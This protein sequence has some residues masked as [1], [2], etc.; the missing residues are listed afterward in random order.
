[1]PGNV[2]VAVAHAAL[3]AGRAADTAARDCCWCT[4]LPLNEQRLLY[5]GRQLEDRH[6]LADYGIRRGSTLELM[7][8]LR[9]GTRKRGVRRTGAAQ[10]AANAQAQAVRSGPLAATVL[11]YCY[12]LLQ[13]AAVGLTPTEPDIEQSL[14]LQ[15]PLLAR[16]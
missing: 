4:G 10:A 8:R 11:H 6:M 15:D 16:E 5:E 2:A 9:G 14:R 7:L 12:S 3:N 13:F 1:M